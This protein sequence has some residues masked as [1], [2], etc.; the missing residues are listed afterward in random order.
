MP[1]VE[2]DPLAGDHQRL[3][4]TRCSIEPIEPPVSEEEIYAPASITH[5]RAWRFVIEDE[6]ARDFVPKFAM[7]KVESSDPKFP[8]LAFVSRPPWA[9]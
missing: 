2:P 8:K 7:P 5:P 4:P 9:G 6:N 1:V 3:H